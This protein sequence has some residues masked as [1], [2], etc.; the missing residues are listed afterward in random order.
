MLMSESRLKISNPQRI[1]RILRRICQA[2]LQVMVRASGEA[3]VAVKG[4]AAGV[5]LDI[6]T[7]TLRIANISDKGVVHLGS[8]SRVQIEFIMM[9]TKVMFVSNIIAREHSAIHV[10]MPTSLVSI[11]RRKNARHAST[12]DL[13]AFLQLSVWNPHVDDVAGPPFFPHHADIAGYVPVGDLSFGGV[14][15]VTRFPAI[16]TVLRRGLID[17][18]AKLI[19]P[20]QDP[21]DC[22]VE[23]RWFKRIKEHVKLPDGREDATAFM[24]SYR[25]G[26]EFINPSDQIRLSIRQFIQQLSQ[27]GAI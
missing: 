12:E 20:M 11:E 3:S 1:A 6:A 22:G 4:R 7:P 19:L 16:N 21:V 13:T 17:D 25:F 10:S 26:L 2:S 5:Q 14:C 24:R 8:K 15:A 27:A 9:S 23:V 18:R